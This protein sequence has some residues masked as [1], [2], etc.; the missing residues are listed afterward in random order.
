MLIRGTG[1]SQIAMGSCKPIAGIGQISTGICSLAPLSCFAQLSPGMS[2]SHWLMASQIPWTTATAKMSPSTGV[3][4]GS[5]C[6]NLLP[7]LDHGLDDTSTGWKGNIRCSSKPSS[8][9][10]PGVPPQPLGCSGSQQQPRHSENSH[11]NPHPPAPISEPQSCL[12]TLRAQSSARSPE[13]P[14]RGTPPGHISVTSST[15]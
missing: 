5:D 3:T 14:D 15:V 12:H 11:E 10:D 2:R 4:Q 9:S 6:S 1:L 8:H 7:Q 13:S